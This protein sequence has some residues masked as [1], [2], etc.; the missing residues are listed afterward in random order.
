M[1]LGHEVKAC[2]Q[3]QINLAGSY[4]SFLNNLPVLKNANIARYRFASDPAGYNP[5]RDRVLLIRKAEIKKLIP[6][7]NEKGIT[8]IPLEVRAGKHIKLVFG[9]G[10]G[11]KKM[12]KRQKIKEKEMKNKLKKGH[13]Y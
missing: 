1:L 2:R 5:L 8:L 6:L 11:I 12:D 13:E 10:R 4:V 9:L 3:G 7:L